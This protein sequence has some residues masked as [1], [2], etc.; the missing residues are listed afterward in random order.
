VDAGPRPKKAEL[1]KIESTERKRQKSEK[2]IVED[3]EKH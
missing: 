2:G 1:I 3:E